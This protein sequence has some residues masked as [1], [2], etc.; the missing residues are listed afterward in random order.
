MRPRLLE[1]LDAASER[2]VT[3]IAAPAGYGKTTLA[4]QWLR[5]RDGE[6]VWISL[7]S[8]DNDPERF[9]RY[10][11]AGFDSLLPDALPRTRALL[12]AMT[13]PP[14]SY[15]AQVLLSELSELD[16]P[17]TLAFDDFQR[18]ASPGGMTQASNATRIRR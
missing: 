16:A 17:I 7:D 18:S 13:A 11:V 9:A 4:L 2:R 12:G 3:L 6:L 14:W 1:R 8:G 5:Q 10:L 15:L